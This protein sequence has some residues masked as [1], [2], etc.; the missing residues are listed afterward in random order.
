MYRVGF[1]LPEHDE[2]GVGS[3]RERRQKQR[4]KGGGPSQIE[5]ESYIRPS[6]ASTTPKR[7]K[8]RSRASV[9]AKPEPG[10][11][12]TPTEIVH[13]PTPGLRLVSMTFDR[14]RKSRRLTSPVRT[15]NTQWQRDSPTGRSVGPQLLPLR[16]VSII[17]R[18][19]SRRSSTLTFLVGTTSTACVQVHSFCQ[20]LSTKHR[21]RLLRKPSPTTGVR[22][23]IVE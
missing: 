8:T 18:P 11:S 10:S 4:Q 19:A 7:S 5:S 15:S 13:V 14:S 16:I 2:P 17:P 12:S 20:I 9:P 1:P 23:A 3:K 6:S 22:N 21:A